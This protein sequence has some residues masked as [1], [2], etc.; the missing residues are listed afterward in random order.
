MMEPVDFSPSWQRLAALPEERTIWDFDAY[1]ER[2]HSLVPNVP[3]AVLKQWI[4]GLQDEYVTRRNYAWLDYDHLHFGLE[5]WPTQDLLNLYVVEE[6]RDCIET[7]ARC[8]GYDEFCC[9]KRDLTHWKVH[10]TWQTP[11]V[12]L[13]VTS[14][15][16]LPPEKELVAPYQLVEGHNRLGYLHAM[17]GMEQQG[18][19][20]LAVK[21]EVWVL[22]CLESTQ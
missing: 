21:H 8:Q 13:D 18:K 17:N 11:P 15:G 19:A 20:E 4:H 16:T 1:Y 3:K 14:L 12:V 6:Y 9:T 7:R 2:V 5:Q 22:R 10:G